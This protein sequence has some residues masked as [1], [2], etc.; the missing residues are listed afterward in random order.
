M[1]L[2]LLKLPL[3]HFFETSFG[4]IHDKHFLLVRLDDGGVSGFGECVAEQD[5]YYSSETND[6]AWH[7]I[8]SFIAPRVLGVDFA[9]PRDLFAA[10]KAI[11]GHHM[12]DCG[13]SAHDH[14]RWL[15]PGTLTRS[16]TLVALVLGMA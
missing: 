1:E 13:A 3:V 7:I 11:R 9:H 5:P 14:Q 4:R 8:E 10:L 15:P 2:R 6:T 16:S 12:W